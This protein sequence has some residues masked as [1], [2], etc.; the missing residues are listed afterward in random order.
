MET[1]R[2][3]SGNGRNFTLFENEREVAKLTYPK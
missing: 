3:N 2:I 1:Y